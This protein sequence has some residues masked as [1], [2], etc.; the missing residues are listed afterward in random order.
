MILLKFKTREDKVNGYY[1][2]AL[3]GTVRSLPND[4]FEVND[5]MLGFLKD[6]NIGFE[7]IERTAFDEAEKIRNTPAIV[8]Q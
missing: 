8:I 2:L 1:F 6:E 5:Y 3:K 4:I 7:V